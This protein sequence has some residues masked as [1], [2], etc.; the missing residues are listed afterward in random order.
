IL[1][2][3]SYLV[4]LGRKQRDI[5][6]MGLFFSLAVFLT[7]FLIGLGYLQFLDYLTRFRPISKFIFA[8]FGILTIILGLLNI[9]DFLQ[10]RTGRLDRMKLQLPDYIKI[11]IHKSIKAQTRIFGIVLGAF[12]AGLFVSILEFACT[13]QVYIPTITFVVSNP[14]LKIRAITFLTLYNIMFIFPLVIITGVGSIVSTDRVGKFLK[15]RIGTIK[16]MTA[17][18]FITLGI[19]LIILSS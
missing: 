2:F 9:Y 5:I 10:A 19:L 6:L 14:Q 12:G 3:I 4:L 11:Q 13:G 15:A 18:F 17:L 16:V 7:Y 1:F 8:G